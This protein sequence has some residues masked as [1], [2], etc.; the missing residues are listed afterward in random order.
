MKE[1]VKVLD[2]FTF[3]KIFSKPCLITLI[4]K[5]TVIPV[6]IT[7]IYLSKQGVSDLGY[8][9]AHVSFHL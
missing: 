9:R 5:D 1:R 8:T 4:S 3:C 7:A 2:V 6:A